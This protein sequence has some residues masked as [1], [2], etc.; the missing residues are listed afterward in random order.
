[1]VIYRG[2]DGGRPKHVSEAVDIASLLSAQLSQNFEIRVGDGRPPA[3]WTEQSEIKRHLSGTGRI[4]PAAADAYG[5]ALGFLPLRQQIALRLQAH[6]IAV[7]EDGLLLTFG[8]I[9]RST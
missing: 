6:Q 5:S 9:T 2:D 4:L 3:S 7:K 1:M 8:P